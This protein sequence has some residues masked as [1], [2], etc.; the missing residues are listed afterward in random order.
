MTPLEIQN[1]ID[2]SISKSIDATLADAVYSILKD[3]DSKTW[4][5]VI[6]DVWQRLK[7]EYRRRKK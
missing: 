1:A 7:A 5:I 4:D 6:H 3:Y 2:N